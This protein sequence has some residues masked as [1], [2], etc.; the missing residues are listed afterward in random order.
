MATITLI[1]GDFGSDTSVVVGEEAFYL[2]DPA[3]PGLKDLVPFTAVAS[4]EPVSD[5]RSGQMKQAAKLGLRGLTTLGPVGLAASLLAVSKVKDMTFEVRLADGRRF[6]ATADAVTYANLRAATSGR[7]APAEDDE[8]A[9][10][11]ADEV[12]ARYLRE[13]RQPAPHTTAAAPPEPADA[14]TVGR[15]VSMPITAEDRLDVP[16]A[17]DRP[18]FGRRRR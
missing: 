13:S 12:I 8:E 2:P 10:A 17:P 7:G 9:A 4:V 15:P 1:A 3:R 11:R 6:T 18:V 16:A 14:E 5:D